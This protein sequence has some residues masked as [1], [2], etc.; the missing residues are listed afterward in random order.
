MLEGLPRE[1]FLAADSLGWAYQLWQGK[2]KEEVNASQVKIGADELPPVTQLFTEP[3]MVEYLLHNTVGSWWR[4]RYPQFAERLKLRYIAP[5]PRAD[6]EV[7]SVSEVGLTA[8]ADLRLLD[9]CCGSGHFLVAAF[10]LLVPMRMLAEGMTTQD[11]VTAVLRDNLYGVE[12]D[13][14]C[15]EIAVFVLALAAWAYPDE[16]G[17]ALGFGPL[18]SLNVACA[19]KSFGIAQ[20]DLGR[21]AFIAQ[22][23][24]LGSLLSSDEVA[25]A[26]TTD[27]FAVRP[28]VKFDNDELDDQAVAA[29]G[30]VQAM[31]I[32]EQRYDFVLTNPPFLGRGRMCDEMR[33]FVE[34]RFYEGRHDLGAVF[35]E[36]CL[37]LVKQDGVAG[38]VLQQS[39]LF[40]GSYAPHRQKLLQ[41]HA[42]RLVANLGEGAFRSPD[43]AGAFPSL[44]VLERQPPLEMHLISI[45]DVSDRRSADEKAAA[46]EGAVVGEL[47]FALVR[48]KQ[49]YLV[50]L[51][52][53]GGLPLL[54]EFATPYVGLQT[55]D[56]PRY[57]RCFWEQ[58]VRTSDW[59]Y[60]QEAPE[61]AGKLT[62]FSSL[63]YWQQGSG[64][65][66]NSG[67]AYIRGQAAWGKAGVAVSRMRQ[68]K[69]S[70]YVGNFYNQTTAAIIPNDESLLPALLA[71]C[72]S[73]E[74]NV[75]V[76]EV[77]R[78]ICVANAALGK[79]GFDVERWTL[80]ADRQFP[81]G[82]PE[83]YTEDPT[84]WMF[85][86]HPMASSDPLHVAV[87]R[88]VGYQWPAERD[89]SVT[90]SP[91]LK[92]W[93]ERCSMLAKHTADDGILC[94]QAVRGQPAAHER[95]LALLI[96]SWETAS[97]GSWKTYVLERL[98]DG[99][100]CA[101][102]SLESWLRDKFFDQ[103]AR[104]FKNRPFV[105]HV[106][107]GLNDG[108]S[109]LVNYHSLDA[110]GL[111]LLIH[112]Y[113][114]DWIRTQEAG[115]S[116][117]VDGAQQRL[118]AAL[119][120]KKRL[121]S[122][123]EGEAP[124]DIFIRWKPCQAQ[125]RG[126]QPDIDD[127]VR[128]NIRPFMK[129]EVLRYN[130]HP[131]LNIKWETDRGQ[132]SEFTPWFGK[133]N[134][135]RVND[136]HLTLAEKRASVGE[137]QSMASRGPR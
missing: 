45:V 28:D 13:A 70:Q 43:A 78:R 117:E 97:P 61:E 106:C 137:V 71:F 72:S 115:A 112:T 84:Q 4:Q 51:T 80:E 69:T 108:F 41:R 107:D 63:F 128:L 82:L 37:N 79:V 26:P 1:L 39:W 127:G 120:L 46:L 60:M 55:S 73:D 12:L 136:H 64:D 102:R 133:F 32:L 53:G 123:A 126:W 114:G 27:L 135:E 19:G 25:A 90:T 110:R 66:T 83:L 49:D 15:V 6:G 103:H 10:H 119:N 30:L 38:C 58:A 74:Y 34:E 109:A 125:S 17:Q 131:K 86:G 124:F 31:Q 92:L 111:D 50:A 65:L 67:L 94:L 29:Q 40:A 95:L 23:P 52:Q 68:L 14:R 35:L 18:P 132:E 91:A 56:Y 42:L 7:V 62:G 129:A 16:H 93:I 20:A 22:A 100:G 88:L 48:A 76:R 54:S 105:W 96:D 122:I 81:A 3:Y 121:I 98:L 2:R 118:A 59:E 8:L 113:L 36:R 89:E 47:S 104:L 33:A 21:S 24:L 77:D 11:A 44:L 57:C 5:L 116:T 130:R 75:A 9:P 87:A 134:G 85:H 99:V 101:G